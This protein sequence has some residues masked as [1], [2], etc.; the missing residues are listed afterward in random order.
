MTTLH[1]VG[2][3][4]PRCRMIAPTVARPQQLGRPRFASFFGVTPLILYWKTNNLWHGLKAM[5]LK[6]FS[7]VRM[8][9]K[10][11]DISIS[12]S[13]ADLR[14]NFIK[15]ARCGTSLNLFFDIAHSRTGSHVHT[16]SCTIVRHLIE[17]HFRC[18]IS[19]G[20]VGSM[21]RVTA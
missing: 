3:D 8:F 14:T 6:S 15:N 5:N 10:Q 17:A 4:G 12:V 9:T 11:G 13:S 21:T 2:Q 1:R 16:Q 18:E 19:C 20:V 7:A